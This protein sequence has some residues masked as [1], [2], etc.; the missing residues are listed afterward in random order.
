MLRLALAILLL[1]AGFLAAQTGG[2]FD[3]SWTSGTEG[4]GGI[5]A[6][7]VGTGAP[8]LAGSFVL[9][10]VVGQPDA[11]PL[12]V[13][14]QYS[15][16]GG[17]LQAAD[18]FP[19]GQDVFPPALL[20]FDFTPTSICTA[21]SSQNVTLFYQVSDNLSGLRTISTTFRSPSGSETV[22]FAEDLT[23]VTGTPNSGTYQ[24]SLTFPQFSELGTWQVMQVTLTDFVGNVAFFT[25][26]Q[27]IAAGFDTTLLNVCPSISPQ[28]VVCGNLAGKCRAGNRVLIRGCALPETSWPDIDQIL[29]EYRPNATSTWSA[30]PA[31]NVNHPNP[32]TTHPFF[33]HWDISGLVEGDYDVRAVASGVGGTD[34][35]PEFIT[36]TVDSSCGERHEINASGETQV[37]A[38]VTQTDRIAVSTA[39]ENLGVLVDVEIPS[40]ALIA[41]TDLIVRVLDPSLF[42]GTLGALTGV[43]QF[44]D[45][46]LAS[47]QVNFANGRRATITFNYPD[48]DGDGR[49]DGTPVPETALG[50]YWYDGLAWHSLGDSL[51]LPSLNRCVGTTTHFTPFAL[52]STTVPAELSVFGTD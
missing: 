39:D 20:N 37:T 11:G 32:D 31:A 15:L 44:V 21:D 17:L 10:Q 49:V 27:L 33:V 34:P 1:P 46:S 36:F 5:S 9:G 48:S 18:I 2:S 24:K 7:A 51:V 8:T 25:T 6:G 26:S 52:L 4:G 3:L 30:I 47:G 43:G 45:L 38:A 50:I 14:G 29:F 13:G 16:Q 22:S 41:D 42:D 19:L 28:A 12:H 40:G 23:P 35:S